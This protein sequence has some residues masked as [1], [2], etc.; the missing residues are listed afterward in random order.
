MEL[1]PYGQSSR[2][3][4]AGKGMRV[5]RTDSAVDGFAGIDSS[6]GAIWPVYSKEAIIMPDPILD[7]IWRVREELLKK[8][9]GLS[10]YFRYVKKLERA[11]RR[12]GGKV[13]ATK[14]RRGKTSATSK[15]S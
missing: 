3:R 1:R 6:S 8:H 14:A 4:A 5:G 10:G 12:R 15:R 9:G 13:K 11:H 2:P 7:E